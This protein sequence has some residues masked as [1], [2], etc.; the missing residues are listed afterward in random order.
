MKKIESAFCASACP[1][2]AHRRSIREAV[3]VV[4]MGILVSTSGCSLG[5]GYV[6][7]APSE[8]LCLGVSCINQRPKACNANAPGASRTS[9]REDGVDAKDGKDAKE[10]AEGV[11]T[12]PSAVP[13]R[14]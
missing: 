9:D 2:T 14:P 1:R 3:M 13:C 7:L 6:T 8:V 4:Q 10:H 11:D 5:I 12:S